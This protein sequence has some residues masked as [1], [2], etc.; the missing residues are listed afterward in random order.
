MKDIQF[1]TLKPAVMKI[2]SIKHSNKTLEDIV[3]EKRNKDYGAY[4]LNRKKRKYLLFS[5]LI[6]LFFF[7]TAIA[8]PFIKSFKGGTL[9]PV[10]KE[11]HV[12]A[13]IDVRDETDIIPPPPPPPAPII[14]ELV[15]YRAPQIIEGPPK[16]VTFASVDELKQ[17]ITNPPPP[18]II[19]NIEPI[20]QEIDEPEPDY[21]WFP[22][23][24]ATFRGGD[25]GDFSIWV[26]ENLKYPETALAHGIFGKV[27]LEFTVSTEGK[28]TD[29]KVLRGVDPLIDLE[30]IRVLS[31]SPLWKPARQGGVKVRQKFAIPIVFQMVE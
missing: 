30:A 20:P 17:Q 3:F 31:A 13:L 18:D 23:E 26:L 21:T 22:E 19:D 12:V 27:I 25:L 28:V 16:E 2:E 15:A 9:K 29:I 4:L 24:R 10:I 8:V 7:S 11:Q 6:S 14:E 5:F 1:Q